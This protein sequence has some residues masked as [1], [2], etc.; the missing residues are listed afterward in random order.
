M[1]LVPFLLVVTYSVLVDVFFH[2]QARW[3][4]DR[5]VDIAFLLVAVTFVFSFLWY[6]VAYGASLLLGT[7]V[8]LGLLAFIARIPGLD[9]HV[10]VTP[11]TRPDTA[12]EVWGRFGLL[13]L[14]LLG[15][16]LIFMIVIVRGGALEPRLVLNRPI[17]FFQDEAI[18]GVLLAVLLAPAG[19]YFAG[20][21]RTRITDSLEFPLLWLAVLLLVVGGVSVLT[22]EV[23]PGVVVDPGLFLISVLFYAPAPWFVALAFSRTERSVQVRFLRRAWDARGGRFHIGRIQVVDEPERTVTDA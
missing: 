10:I 1:W 6:A 21:L 18:A 19:A 22:V 13:L 20:R 7:L 11:P 14:I 4:G 23:L 16:E 5:L 2:D 8:P 17:V 3:T 15:F 9:R 12:R